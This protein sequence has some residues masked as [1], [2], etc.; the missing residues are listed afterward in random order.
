MNPEIIGMTGAALTTC[1]FIPQAIKTVKSRDTRG[2]SAWM[3]GIFSAG[4]FCWLIY[5]FMLSNLPMILANG[6]T[7]PLAL[8]ILYVK[9]KEKAHS[10]HSGVSPH[11]RP[12]D[13]ASGT[14]D[15]PDPPLH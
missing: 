12:S 11:A 8:T 9:L 10:E 7:L 4:V 15:L 14:D 3:Y 6:V 13:L 5:G 1:C 2:I